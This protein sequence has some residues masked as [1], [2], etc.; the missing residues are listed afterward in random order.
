MELSDI[1]KDKA[2]YPDNLVWNMGNNVSVTLGQL[3]SLSA[4][5]QKRITDRDADLTKRQ[6]ELETES[7]K[8][9]KAQTDTANV[10]VT[11]NTAVEAMKAGRYNDPVLVQLFGNM[12]PNLPG[13]GNN[14]N[15]DDP[16]RALAALEQDNVL[17]PVVKVI[18]AVREEAQKAQKAVADNIEVQK[19][20]ATSYINGTLE[21]RYDRIVPADKQDK[22]TLE[23]L[24]RSAVA[25][26]QFTSDNVP[27][28]KWAYK[29]AT[30]GDDA[31]AREV[32]IRADERKKLEAELAARGQGG[33]TGTG[34]IFVPQPQSF[35]LDVHNRSGAAPKPFASL[36]EAFKAAAAD[37]DI[38][39]Q[40]DGA[41][42]Q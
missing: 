24:I 36:D 17:G 30:A 31:A 15:A 6:T 27:N 37:K 7:A 18:K 12:A 29:Q 21:D 23:S 20:M 8:L 33:G 14:Q 28:I 39:A 32:A 26:Q 13:L 11:L 1:L 38:W 22:I 16:F 10:Y 9:K 19:K 40:V 25:A 42:V 2:Q 41:K 3:R 4:A 5:E 35:G 34:D